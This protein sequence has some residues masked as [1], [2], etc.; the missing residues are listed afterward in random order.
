M[1]A[2]LPGY[3]SWSL[4]D[5]DSTDIVTELWLWRDILELSGP[6]DL[7]GKNSDEIPGLQHSNWSGFITSK[8]VT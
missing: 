3:S 7:H 2:L 1:Q 6:Y 8:A 4:D 5:K